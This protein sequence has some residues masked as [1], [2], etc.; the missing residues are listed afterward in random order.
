MLT[1][2][3]ENLLVYKPRLFLYMLYLNDDTVFNIQNC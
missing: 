3:E 2:N 1:F